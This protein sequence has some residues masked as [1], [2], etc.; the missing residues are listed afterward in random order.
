[1]SNLIQPSE[2]HASLGDPGLRLV[3]AR[4]DL[5]DPDAGQ[6]AFDEGHVPGAVYV[7]LER[8]LSAPVS[9]HGGR[10]PLPDPA[11]LATRLGELGIGN[12]SRVVVYDFG[13]GMVASRFWWLLR[14]LGH[15]DVRVLDGGF[16]A[17]REAGLPV[18][19]DSTK[20]EV[21]RFVPA[22]RPELVVDRDY[23]LRNL[24]N[25][26]VVLV[27]A[28][29]GSRYRGETEPLDPVAGHIPSA[30]NFAYADNLEGGRFKSSDALRERYEPLSDAD[31]LVVYCGSGVSAAHDVLA[32]E[33]AGLSGAR[34]Y[35]GSW[36]DWCSYQD[37][38]VA[39][40]E[41]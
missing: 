36:S 30:V 1:M 4:F 22:L 13:N 28:R 38:P 33:E 16:E 37:S 39:T 14:H 27:D 32:L 31:E 41:E 7:H 23:V 11:V 6:R 19:K 18:S 26:G 3:D 35:A 15:D 29:A 20:P 5:A 9:R 25:P 12:D 2:L 17:W 10:H 40:G 24:G 8:D 21:A 34:L